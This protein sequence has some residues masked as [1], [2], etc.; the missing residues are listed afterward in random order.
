MV[1]QH[2]IPEGNLLGVGKGL[3]DAP[4]CVEIGRWHAVEFI[5]KNVRCNAE[6]LQHVARP[7]NKH[8][9]TRHMIVDRLVIGERMQDGCSYLENG[10]RN[11]RVQIRYG[12]HNFV[13]T[14]RPPNDKLYAPSRAVRHSS[15]GRHI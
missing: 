6:A 1:G 9:T 14:S 8:T 15:L 5:D 12:Y 7:G 3:K 10:G 4:E 13:F 2:A 11:E